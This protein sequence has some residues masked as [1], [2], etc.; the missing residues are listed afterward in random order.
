MVVGEPKRLCR[1]PQ[2]SIRASRPPRPFH[3]AGIQ[4]TYSCGIGSRRGCVVAP[5][6][7]RGSR[8][9]PRGSPKHVDAGGKS[10]Q[11]GEASLSKAHTG[12]PRATSRHG[13]LPTQAF[14]ELVG[15]GG[16]EGSRDDE[17]GFTGTEKNVNHGNDDRTLAPGSL[18]KRAR[19]TPTGHYGEGDPGTKALGRVVPGELVSQ[20]TRRL[21]PRNP[22][23]FSEGHGRTTDRGVWLID[24]RDP[25]PPP[26][27]RRKQRASPIPFTRSSIDAS[28]A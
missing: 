27:T 7:A 9:G 28:P 5:W 23:L 20:D 1:R 26:P 14:F 22:K 11:A 25:P 24:A 21:P 12:T 2:R 19:A 10:R 8:G 16:G 13:E 3:E 18:E 15:R 4:T 17:H 6:S